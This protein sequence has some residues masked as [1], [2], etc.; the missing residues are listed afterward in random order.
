M[1]VDGVNALL[2]SAAHRQLALEAAEQSAVLLKNTNNA[3]PL[4]LRGKN[5]RLHTDELRVVD[6]KAR[7]GSVFLIL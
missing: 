4:T 7:I 3:L 1:P 5:V 6:P 2:D